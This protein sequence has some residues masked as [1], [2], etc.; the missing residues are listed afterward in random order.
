M[1]NITK[2]S[3]IT[4]FAI[5]VLLLNQPAL[6]HELGGHHG[7]TYEV[8][9]PWDSPSN[10]R[11]IQLTVLEASTGKPTPARFT[12]TTDGDPYLPDALGEGL[13]QVRG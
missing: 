7:P 12:I 9:A 4:I 2:A 6:A 10:A 1:N 11:A 5:L 3:K 13:L 8:T